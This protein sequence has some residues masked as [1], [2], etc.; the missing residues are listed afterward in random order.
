M[1]S[2][3]LFRTGPDTPGGR[4]IRLFWHPVFIAE[5][6]K[7]GWAKPIRILGEDFT[8]YRGE[9]GAPHLLAFRCAHRGMQLSAGWVEGD[10]LRCRYHGWKYDGTGQCVEVPTEDESVAKT[11]R[12]RSYPTEEYLGLIFGYLGEGEAPPFLRYPDFEQ[13]GVIWVEKY[14]RPCNLFNNLEN[15]PVHIPFAHRES[16]IF[17]SRPIEIPVKVEAEESEWGVSLRTTFPGGKVHVSQHGW[18]NVRSWKAPERDH[19]AWRVP[20]DDDSHSSF[21]VDFMHITK[22]EEGEIYRQRH[23]SRE[24]KV[25]RSYIELAEAVLRGDMRIQDIQGDDAAN[26]IWIQDYVTQVGQGK[27]ADRR[28][29]HLIRADVGVLL[30]RKVWERE[31][32]ALAEGRAMKEW[33]RPEQLAATYRHQ[34]AA[35][36]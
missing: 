4:Y 10:C 33:I 36:S 29:E 7:P 11:I 13:E 20:I 9:N 32:M 1:D 28:F 8:L 12:I 24:G 25:G 27:F 3:D 30:Y 23:A 34:R 26:F 35:D 18:P 19:I 6:L 22:G 15:D 17:R 21:Q 2:V 16:E 5:D 31:V 14:V